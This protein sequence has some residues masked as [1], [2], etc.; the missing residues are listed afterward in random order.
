MNNYGASSTA[1]PYNEE[2]DYKSVGKIEKKHLSNIEHWDYY[3]GFCDGTLNVGENKF[4]FLWQDCENKDY[5]TRRI[6]LVFESFLP[7]PENYLSYRQCFG[8][9]V[10]GYFT[11]DDI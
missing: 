5:S 8:H 11:E 3:D 9:N 4:F 7:S 10:L 1:K 2:F 6:Y